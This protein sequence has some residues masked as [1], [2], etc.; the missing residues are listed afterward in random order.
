MDM[1]SQEDLKQNLSNG[2][3][4]PCEPTPIHIWCP[5]ASVDIALQ[6]GYLFLEVGGRICTLATLNHF[7]L[8]K[9]K[10]TENPLRGSTSC[11]AALRR[12]AHQMTGLGQSLRG[13]PFADGR[14]KSMG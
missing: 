1:D 5:T 10:K 3:E 9:A 14:R 13:P 12:A 7:I 8:Q 2:E 6:L 11:A 4:A